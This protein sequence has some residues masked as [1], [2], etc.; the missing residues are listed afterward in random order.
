[1]SKLRTLLLLFF[2]CSIANAQTTLQPGTPIDRELRPGEVHQ[3][4]VSAEANNFIQL[5][6]EQRGIDVIVRVNSPSGKSLGEFDS[7]NGND[8]LENVSFVAAD[9]GN[10]RV[11]V[12]RFD[13][14][15]RSAGHYQIK[16][17]ELRQA[18]DEELKAIKNLEVTKARGIALLAE[19]EGTIPQIKSSQTR[20][21]AQLQASQ[22]LWEVDEKR[23]SKLLGDATTG[24]KDFLATTEPAD[25]LYQQSSIGQLRF[26][27]VTTLAA[28]DPDAALSFLQSTTQFFNAV[29]D[30]REN[31]RVVTSMELLIA[32][33]AMRNDPNR[34]L[35]IARQSLKHGYASNLV[36]MI[37]RLQ[38]QKPELAAELGNEVATKLS[39]ENLLKNPEAAYLTVNLLQYSRESVQL[40][41]TN[42]GGP[43]AVVSTEK[44]N[45]LV[46]RVF[47]QATSYSSPA[48]ST[49][50]RQTYDPI[51]DSA[52]NMLMALQSLSTQVDALVPGGIAAVQKKMKDLNHD[53]L[54]DLKQMV[55]PPGNKASE[56]TL[57]T[58]EK[59][60]AELKEQQYIELAYKEANNGDPARARQII[61]NHITNPYQRRQ[62]LLNL[63]Q[64]EVF[65][66]M[67]QGQVDEALRALA[68]LRNSRERARQLAQIAN[69]IGPGLKRTT[70]LN[71]LEQAR[72]LLGPSLVAQDQDEMN[73][74][75]EIA[76]AFSRYDVK[77]AFE[78]IDPLID[79]FN[80]LI[81][82]ARTLDGFGTQYYDG[83]E[84]DFQNGNP[85]ALLAEPMS[86]VLGGVAV[87][88][89]D[90]AK[91]TTDRLRAPELRL[92]IY[93]E[94]A[95]QTIKGDRAPVR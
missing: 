64:Q 22:V 95:K 94:I 42:A 54:S 76:R 87:I 86:A 70:A 2:L 5:V 18:T 35:Q 29:T 65:R 25:V 79:Q 57:E 49:P 31:A 23:A 24:F 60:P 33:Q 85:L 28:R 91:S 46:R 1:M 6:V 9:A 19:I 84:L 13:A 74:L 67:N 71:L 82:A 10:Y 62:T 75:L 41:S 83:E 92:K 58:I 66:A 21:R 7:P 59:M 68:G 51:K 37:A 52:I 32:D 56:V 20:I 55:T 93:L 11:S 88:N 26:E 8:G 53:M 27:L 17:L 34:A 47:D 39:T 63:E 36:N 14:K 43:P 3:F 38:G 77:R 69:L 45:E 48:S 4:T 50:A 81:G 30:K 90:L 73:A 89:F 40:Q 61:N 44:F 15:D 80:D 12:G 72:S 16:I 78:I